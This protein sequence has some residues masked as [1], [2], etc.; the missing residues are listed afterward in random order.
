MCYNKYVI[1]DRF[2]SLKPKGIDTMEKNTA[3][4]KLT[5]AQKFAILAELPEVKSN[6]TLSE[7]IAHELELLAKKNTTARKPT[8]TQIAN[9]A[10]KIS[11][12]ESMEVGAKYTISDLIKTVP[13]CADLST[14]KVSAVVRQLRDEGKVVRIEDKRKVYFSLV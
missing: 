10:L 8:A 12:L 11:I 9:E 3:T 5:K 13:E 1:K 4:T 6:P 2:K 14:S 7:F